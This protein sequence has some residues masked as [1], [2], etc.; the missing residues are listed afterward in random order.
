M[1]FKYIIVGAGLAGITM[2]ERIAT[3]LH[4]RVLIIEKEHILAETF[5]MNMM[6]QEY[7]FNCTAAHIPYE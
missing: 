6:Q 1:R 7:L 3:Q 4:E 5:M 2:A